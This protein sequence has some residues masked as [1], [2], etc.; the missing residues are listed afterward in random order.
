MCILIYTPGNTTIPRSH[1]EEACRSNPDGFGWAI[2][3]GDRILMDKGM[4]SVD[5]IDG[6]LQWREEF[7]EYP[8]LFHARITTH[9]L[10]NTD[11]CHPFW[12]DGNTVIAHNGII[13]AMDDDPI[14]SDTR[15]FAEDWMP[16]MIPYLDDEE[17]F[18]QL[19]RFIGWSKVVVLTVDPLLKQ[20]AYILNESSGH[21]KD[22]VWY[23]NHSYIPYVYTGWS[24]GSRKYAS[25]SLGSYSVWKNGEKIT[26]HWDREQLKY[27]EES[28]FNPFEQVAKA[29][30]AL[31]RGERGEGE[32]E[33]WNSLASSA[34][35]HS[36]GRIQHYCKFCEESFITQFNGDA[37]CPDCKQ[38]ANCQH[39]KCRCEP[40]DEQLFGGI[41]GVKQIPKESVFSDPDDWYQMHNGTVMVWDG[42]PSWATS[43]AYWRE[44]TPEEYDE[45]FSLFGP[46]DNLT[47]SSLDDVIDA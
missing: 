13:S 19:E 7:P 47:A 9:G 29:M 14:R 46:F 16:Y 35:G 5:I 28:E 36:N 44:A 27:V 32:D 38:C 30:L 40:T 31:P 23:S 18:A 11:N 22:N 2:I 33:L 8:S 26:Y 37:T 4:N 20:W 43:M 15:V 21:W 42:N 24:E 1:L 17:E 3:A 6:Y 45:F 41:D 39:W 10:T 25:N 12:V 34:G